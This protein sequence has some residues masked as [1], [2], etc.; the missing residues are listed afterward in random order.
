MPA[1]EYQALDEEG[2]RR[3][4]VLGPTA[5]AGAHAARTRPPP[6]AVDAVQPGTRRHGLGL[7]RSRL[8]AAQLTL[9][10][11]ELATLLAAG[12]PIDDALGAMTDQAGD[13]HTGTVLAS[14]RTRVREGAG[15]GRR[16][17]GTADSFPGYFAPRWRRPSSP[18]TSTR[19]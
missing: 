16:L 9:L 19:C 18:A 5:P 15:T 8:S 2:R 7:F 6:L 11:R 17:G 3:N 4:G 12:L 10:T 13:E 14:L 1:F